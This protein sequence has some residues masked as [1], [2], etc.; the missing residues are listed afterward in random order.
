LLT[1]LQV[2][3]N[4]AHALC[5]IASAA[6]ESSPLLAELLSED[7][8]REVFTH[9][10]HKVDLDSSALKH[11][12]PLLSTLIAHVPVPVSDDPPLPPVLS[13]FQQHVP[14]VKELL[15][16]HSGNPQLYTFGEL[17]PPFG[18]VRM[19]VMEICCAVMKSK[20][21]SLLYK[22]FVDDGLFATC[23]VRLHPSNSCEAP[24]SPPAEPFF[25]IRV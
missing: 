14:R 1:P 19:K 2:H 11:S 7:V 18:F 20:Y 8:C 13:I 3:E 22:V 10:F 4:A 12:L 23:M 24:T 21:E 17:S 16:S 9:A 25:P 15:E 5:E 6:H